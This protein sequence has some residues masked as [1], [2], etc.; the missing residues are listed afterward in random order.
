MP[1][2]DFEI[3]AGS[4]GGVFTTVEGLL[5]KARDHLASRS[6]TTGDSAQN[7]QDKERLEKFLVELE[8]VSL[9][10]YSMESSFYYFFPLLFTCTPV[11]AI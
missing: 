1:E 10:F 3:A 5:I 7:K 8:E 6:F 11:L 9:L 4:L 2:L